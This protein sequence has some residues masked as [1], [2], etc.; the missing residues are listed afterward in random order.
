MTEAFVISLNPEE[1]ALIERIEFDALKLTGAEQAKRNGELVLK[2]VHSLL[3]RDTIPGHRWSW[4]VDPEHNARGRRSSRR[5]AFERNG[6]RGDDIAR[7]PHFLPYLHYFIYD[8]D[9]PPR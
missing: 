4:F 6:T 7:H 1:Q 5:D 8:P 9:L 2:L 3:S